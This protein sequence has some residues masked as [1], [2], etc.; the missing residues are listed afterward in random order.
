MLVSEAPV[1]IQNDSS[2]AIPAFCTDENTAAL[3]LQPGPDSEPCYLGTYLAR[4][5]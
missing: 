4:L 3:R 1:Y 5:Y 2:G